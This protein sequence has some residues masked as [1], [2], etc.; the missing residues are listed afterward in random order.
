MTAKYIAR[1][2][3]RTLNP[4]WKGESTPYP[5]GN[6]ASALPIVSYPSQAG[7][8]SPDEAEI[9]IAPSY[10]NAIEEYSQLITEEEIVVEPEVETE[11]RTRQIG[12]GSC[13][14]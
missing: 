14:L 3:V 4:E 12:R 7:L 11:Q 2:G 6:R 5:F 13:T 10:Q 1:D 8:F 9:N